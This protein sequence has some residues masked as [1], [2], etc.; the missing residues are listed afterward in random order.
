MYQEGKT[1]VI[2]ESKI[3]GMFQHVLPARALGGPELLYSNI[4]ITGRVKGC[5]KLFFSHLQVNAYGNNLP[6]KF[7]LIVTVWKVPVFSAALAQK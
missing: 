5:R 6:L 3:V 2:A 4:Q 1:I 7:I